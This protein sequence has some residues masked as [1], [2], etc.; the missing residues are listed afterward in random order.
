ML[1]CHSA[2]HVLPVPVYC[3]L[4]LALRQR[5][6]DHH[7]YAVHSHLFC[8]PRPA[9][10][11]VESVSAHL[12]ACRDASLGVL[13]QIEMGCHIASW[14]TLEDYLLYLESLSPDSPYGASLGLA[15]C[16]CG[17]CYGFEAFSR[18]AY[19]ALHGLFRCCRL[20][21]TLLAL[22]SLAV[23]IEHLVVEEGCGSLELQGLV[24]VL[25]CCRH[26]C[27]RHGGRYD[28]CGYLHGVMMCLIGWIY[29]DGVGEM[30]IRWLV[31][32]MMW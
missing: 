11:A 25:S 14:R 20:T 24:C 31:L 5:V 10:L 4:P 28:Y 22:I 17:A 29:H 6:D 13:G 8:R 21:E 3:L 26:G 2:S 19:V 32:T 1:C 15:P 9:A 27:Q 23:D 30:G 7:C 12:Y 16:R 18:C